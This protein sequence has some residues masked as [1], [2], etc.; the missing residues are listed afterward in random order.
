MLDIIGFLNDNIIW[1]IPMLVLMIGTGLYLTVIT[2][3]VIFRHFGILMKYTTATLFKK[4]DPAEQEEGAITPFQ[5]VCTALSAT[6][7]TGNIVG[8]ALAIA[9]GGPGAMFW[10][11]VSALVG[12]VTKYSECML[13]V[14]YRDKNSRGEIIGGPM[15]YITKGLGKRWLAILFCIFGSIAAFGIGATVQ[16]NSL[17]GGVN[18]T[19][20]IPFWVIGVIVAILAGLVLIGGIKR[21][22]ATAEILVPFMAVFYIVGAIAVL[23]VNAA[24]IPQAFVDIF[25]SAFTGAAPV[26][27]FAGATIIYAARIGVARGVF[28][29]EAGM[30]SA[31]IAHASASTD[32]PAR[33]G[34]WG[35]FE[36]FFDTIVMCTITGLVILTS[37]RWMENPQLEKNAMSQAAFADAIPLG[38]YVVTIGLVLFAF[39]TIIAWY[40]YGEKCVEFLF[41][42]NRFVIRIYQVLYTVAV[43]LGCVASLDVVWLF[44]DFFNGL[45]AFP[46]LFALIALSPVIKKLS[47]DLFADPHRIRPRHTDYSRFIKLKG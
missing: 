6:V 10:L 24:A 41:H 28:T 18:A 8:V 38:Q 36:V 19:F 21:I 13:A 9:V 4:Q 1:G 11:W 27:G 14:A 26:G 42:E 31:P 7:G 2:K 43:F 17:A 35:A 47:D 23:V 32:H 44:A 45:M 20:N 34:L 37:G 39:A 5:A 29:H 3:G 15:Q 22:S 30:G 12:M 40:Y 33:Q 16:A 25:K 46:N